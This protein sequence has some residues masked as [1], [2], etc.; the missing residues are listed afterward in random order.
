[1]SVGQTFVMIPCKTFALVEKDP[2]RTELCESHLVVKAL[3]VITKIESKHY[4][5]TSYK[6]FLAKSSFGSEISAEI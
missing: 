5:K 4:L 6:C 1:M 2:K 3:T